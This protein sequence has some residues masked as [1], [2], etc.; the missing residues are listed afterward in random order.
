M[1][2]NTF[3]LLGSM[4][5]AEFANTYWG[6]ST[7]LIPRALSDLPF[8]LDEFKDILLTRAPYRCDGVRL[9]TAASEGDNN[10]RELILAKEPG[11]A[12]QALRE[13]QSVTLNRLERFLK[14][15]HPLSRIYAD[16]CRFIGVGTSGLQIA[17]FFSPPSG[18][19]FGKHMDRNHIFVLQISGEKFWNI[20]DTDGSDK[21]FHL[22]P[23]DVFYLPYGTTHAVHGGTDNSLS[24][25][26]IMRAPTWRD[27]AI[28][29]I[30]NRLDKSGDPR[31]AGPGAL[32]FGWLDQ[33]QPEAWPADIETQ[34]TQFRELGIDNKE[35]LEAA[36][37]LALQSLPAM[38]QNSDPFRS[39]DQTTTITLDT[40][41]KPAWQTPLVRMDMIDRV[42]IGSMSKPQIDGTALLAPALDFI[43]DKN[44]AFAVRDLPDSYDNA[45]KVA[46]CTRLLKASYLQV[47][48]SQ[49]LNG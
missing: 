24:L 11:E 2:T 30:L 28:E 14:T 18:R 41:L 48:E 13:G 9:S 40:L 10:R 45:S 33:L 36:K 29:A 43:L 19:A 12:V 25:T 47:C 27:L 34:A 46:I 4:P 8:S 26:F 39:I 21:R 16:L 17:A 20:T 49:V 15:S 35:W 6:K 44:S 32:P 5:V 37:R 23:G 42:M 3:T 38:P 22:Q 7:H 1:M 31:V